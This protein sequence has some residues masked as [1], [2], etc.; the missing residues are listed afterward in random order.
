MG[1][2]PGKGSPRRHHGRETGK[3]NPAPPEG[4]HPSEGAIAA[5]DQPNANTSSP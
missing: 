4:S 1:P 3:V 2:S 5:T